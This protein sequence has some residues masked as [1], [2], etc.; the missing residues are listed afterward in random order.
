MLL[1][2]NQKFIIYNNYSLKLKK[3]YNNY[4]RKKSK[5]KI[6]ENKGFFTTFVTEI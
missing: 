4:T 2:E 1:P 5:E 3:Y 6:S